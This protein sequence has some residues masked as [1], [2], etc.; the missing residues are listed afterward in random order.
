MRTFRQCQ[1]LTE[2]F[3]W[4]TAERR[5]ENVKRKR[6]REGKNEKMLD[7]YLLQANFLKNG[8]SIF[9]KGVLVERIGLTE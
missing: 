7:R 8:K 9:G 5:K 3:K 1:T 6:E 4:E 2:I